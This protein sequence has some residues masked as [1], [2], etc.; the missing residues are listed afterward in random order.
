MLVEARVHQV[1]ISEPYNVREA[2][3]HAEFVGRLKGLD[4]IKTTTW[5]SQSVKESEY[6]RRA[7]EEN[8]LL[9]NESQ[10]LELALRNI[11]FKVDK[12]TAV[13]IDVSKQL[14]ELADKPMQIAMAPDVSGANHNHKVN[15]HMPNHAMAF[16]NEIMLLEDACSDNLQIH[17]TNG[18]RILA[19]CPQPDQRRP[20]YVLARFNPDVEA[21]IDA[22]RGN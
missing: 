11:E 10:V 15:V 5:E 3:G 20:D 14:A 16:Y 19:A 8:C 4:F 6:L 1:T 17:L 9:L 13:A 18:W 21:P 22:R 7:I 2:K 12:S